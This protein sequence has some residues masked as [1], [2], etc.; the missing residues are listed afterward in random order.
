MKQAYLIGLCLCLFT[1]CK[2]QNRLFEHVRKDV[3]LTANGYLI[4]LYGNYGVWIFQPCK[5]SSIHVLDALNG[6]SFFV[7]DM[8]NDLFLTC[9]KDSRGVGKRIP[10]TFFDESSHTEVRDTAEYLYCR[11]TVVPIEVPHKEDT[12][13]YT[14]KHKL[15]IK[16]LACWSLTN[17][18]KDLEPIK[19]AERDLYLQILRN[20]KRPLPEWASKKREE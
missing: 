9:L 4:N 10:L 14:L 12:C 1:S 18:V 16:G 13:A 7:Q 19:N 8:E 5:D 6:T 20:K 2:A 15:Q 3:P 11:L 17:Y